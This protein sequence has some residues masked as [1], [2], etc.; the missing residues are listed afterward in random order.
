M[1]A[2]APPDRPEPYDSKEVDDCGGLEAVFRAAA[3]PAHFA[4]PRPKYPPP[5]PPPARPTIHMN[6]IVV[7]TIWDLHTRSEVEKNIHEHV[8][9][10]GDENVQKEAMILFSSTLCE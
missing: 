5:P 7:T 10:G 3:G 1:P 8:L 9:S 2:I 4:P 6:N